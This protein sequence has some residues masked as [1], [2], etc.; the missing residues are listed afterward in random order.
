MVALW[1]GGAILTDGRCWSLGLDSGGCGAGG[2]RALRAAADAQCLR[3]RELDGDIAL[4]DAREL[5]VKLK[6][7]WE[8]LD[9]KL[10]D[11]R[12]FSA[13]A[14]ARGVARVGVEVIE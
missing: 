7:G 8:L 9:V 14:L 6:L 4:A 1:R 10:R 13:R 5:S 2:V 11:E 3:V 12:L